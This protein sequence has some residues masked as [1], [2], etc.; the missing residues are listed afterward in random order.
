[1]TEITGHLQT[2]I[3]R[4][5]YVDFVLANVWSI[6]DSVEQNVEANSVIASVLAEL[7]EV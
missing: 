1:M 2:D 3:A 7:A 6:N 5:G 4:A